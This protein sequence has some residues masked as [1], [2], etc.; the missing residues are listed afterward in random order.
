MFDEVQAASVFA[1]L[2]HLETYTQVSTMIFISNNNNQPL[3]AA[4]GTNP[5]ILALYFVAYKLVSVP[6]R[7]S[8]LFLLFNCSFLLTN[9]IGNK[10]QPRRRQRTVSN[11]GV[12]LDCRG[13]EGALYVFA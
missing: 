11:V 8:T 13:E 7:Q 1:V 12:V 9:T 2:A 4:C 5:D 3:N 6:Q 10:G